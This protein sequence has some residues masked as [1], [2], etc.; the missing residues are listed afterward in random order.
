MK[1]SELTGSVQ[2]A[3]QSLGKHDG[4]QWYWAA[5]DA[6]FTNPG[7]YYWDGNKNVLA[8]NLFVLP[9]SLEAAPSPGGMPA[10][11]GLSEGEREALERVEA[12]VASDKM[13]SGASWIMKGGL[14]QHTIDLETLCGTVRRITGE[15][16]E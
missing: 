5:P 13:I 16:H 3:M 8:H 10:A 12:K 1:E 9:P 7:L 2:A 4:V 15:D 14:F 11:A 6:G